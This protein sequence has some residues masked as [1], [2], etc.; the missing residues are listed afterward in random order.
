MKYRIELVTKAEFKDYAQG[1]I[2]RVAVDI[3]DKILCALD[4]DML[5]LRIGEHVITS[6]E[7]VRI[8][9]GDDKESLQK[10]VKVLKDD[11][12]AEDGN[13]TVIENN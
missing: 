4:Q 7:G 9:S 2:D 12:G 8:L 1:K 5:V 11:W 13:D 6:I 10:F 3:S